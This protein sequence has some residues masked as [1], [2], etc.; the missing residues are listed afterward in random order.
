MTT[1]VS[2]SSA[3]SK[4]EPPALGLTTSDLQRAVLLLQLLQSFS[5]L[6]ASL[7][8]QS[9]ACERRED[10][11]EDIPTR[12]RRTDRWEAGRWGNVMHTGRQADMKTGKPAGG[13]DAAVYSTWR[14]WIPQLWSLC[15]VCCFICEENIKLKKSKLLFSSDSDLSIKQQEA[16]WDWLWRDVWI[17]EAEG[18]EVSEIN[19]RDKGGKRL[20]LSIRS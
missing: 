16:K 12:C 4:P 9:R 6:L 3:E 10:W 17:R 1:V 15:T 11:G 19:K 18:R 13:N 7:F 2:L 14:L 8:L 5:E 20:L